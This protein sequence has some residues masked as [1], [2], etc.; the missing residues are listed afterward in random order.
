MM[1]GKWILPT[2]AICNNVT[3]EGLHDLPPAFNQHPLAMEAIQ[4]A[5][6]CRA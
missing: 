4:H 1:D 5:L 6:A 2:F 3:L